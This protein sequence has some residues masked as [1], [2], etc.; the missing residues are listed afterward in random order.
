MIITAILMG[1][2]L[3]GNTYTIFS[4]YSYLHCHKIPKKID[5][6]SPNEKRNKELV[7]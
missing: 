5:K 3:K 6:T 7:R 4:Y 1:Q 2:Q